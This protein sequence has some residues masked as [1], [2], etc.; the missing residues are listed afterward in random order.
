MYVQFYHCDFLINIIQV[1]KL[2]TSHFSGEELPIHVAAS[3]LKCRPFSSLVFCYFTFAPVRI[4]N[5]AVGS[6]NICIQRSG[7]GELTSPDLFPLLN[8]PPTLTIVIVVLGVVC[9]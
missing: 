2:I 4:V 1:I 3:L 6:F 8:C 9:R 5:T 7:S